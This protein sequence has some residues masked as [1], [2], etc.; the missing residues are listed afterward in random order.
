LLLHGF[1]GTHR[2]WDAVLERLPA[3][4]YRPLVPDLCGHGSRAARRPVSFDACVADLAQHA[5]ARFVLC[6]Y[7]L[8]GRVALNLALAHPDRVSRLVLVASTAGIEDGR[9]RE[10]RRRDDEALAEQLEREPF[11]QFIERWRAQPLFADEPPAA[12]EAAL[13]DQRRT[14]PQA[15]AAVLRGLGTGVMTPLWDRLGEL[16]MPARILAGERDA[17][18]TALGRR[19][20]DALPRGTLTIVPGAGHALLHEAPAAVAAAI[21]S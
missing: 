21:A 10:A 4:R 5:P 3:E 20:A 6:G 15:L 12:R 14:E 16:R 2:A 8:G 17:K 7:S 18:F 9:E 11:E 1:S 19:L 13:A